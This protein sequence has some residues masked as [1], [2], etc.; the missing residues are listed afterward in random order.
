MYCN[1]CGMKLEEDALFCPNCGTK[2][3][4]MPQAGDEENRTVL[5]GEQ[6]EEPQETVV[7]EQP[8]ESQ[9]YVVEEQPA[10]P[11]GFV[12]EE[13]AV[14]PVQTEEPQGPV[15]EKVEAVETSPT[16]VVGTSEA[17]VVQAGY[18]EQKKFCPNCGAENGVNDLFC[19][20][21]GMFFG[22]AEKALQGNGQEKQKKNMAKIILPI[23]AAVAVII[24]CIVFVPRILGSLGSRG[25]QKDYLLYIKDNELNMA[26]G[27]KFEPLL[28]DDKCYEDKNDS[29]YSYNYYVAC[30]P[31][32]KYIYYPHNID[33]Y[34]GTY[35][36]YRKKL[37]D[38][39]AEEEKIDS[40][41][42]TYKLID[43]DR[44]AYVKDRD[45]MRLYIYSKGETS[46]VASDVTAW[47]IHVSDDGKNVMWRSNDGDGNLYVQD[48]A[49]KDDKVKLDSDVYLVYA[50]SSDLNL[51]VYEKDD[52]LYIL[53]D[54]EEKEKIASDVENVYVYGINNNL[55]IYYMKEGDEVE[56]T[57]YDL[58]D[59]DCRAADEN[60]VEPLIEDFTTYVDYYVALD[61]YEQ[62]LMRD[63]IRTW[64][65]DEE[66][67]EAVIEIY[68]YDPKKDENDKVMETMVIDGGNL[69][70][71]TALMYLWTV[72]F[73]D[74]EGP[75]MSKVIEENGYGWGSSLAV[76]RAGFEKALL[77]SQ[78]EYMKLQ[79][80]KDGEV[81]EV[82][83]IGIDRDDIFDVD[84]I[85][86]YSNEKTHTM[87]LV[88]EHYS[89]YGDSIWDVGTSSDSAYA[90]EEAAPDIESDWGSSEPESSSSQAY[91]NEEY[92]E[93]YSFDYNEPD[94]D[95][96]L[97]SDE[98]S[99]IEEICDE[100]IYYINE[101]DELY[102]NETK[103]DNDVA[104]Q[105]VR[106]EDGLV[107]YLTD[108]NK[109][110][111]EGTLKLYQDG[112]ASRIANDAAIGRYRLFDGDK[113][114]YMSDFNFNKYRGDLS[115]YDGKE[116]IKV[117]T[118]VQV[119]FICD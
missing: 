77:G 116:S 20:A 113:V 18:F 80:I 28:I 92:T 46:K 24:L 63:E 118:D 72:D 103:I 13:Q 25:N 94:A 71:D 53:K 70:T 87:Y 102:C 78:L 91:S 12:A 88:Y 75:K 114:V 47:D 101:D 108:I 109:D 95:T 52:N 33:S 85:S 99:S 19:Q 79:Y 58:I 83:D 97:V 76:I 15:I 62:K 3:S 22:D 27:S 57:L 84:D 32:N 61:E 36:L 117:D 89:G 43:N 1:N 64:A 90:I 66:M 112:K 82:S 9:G 106:C 11:Q 5:L 110:H 105:T 6:A 96:Q 69:G 73:E 31:D 98:V 81:F 68:H 17:A 65:Q 34:T 115:A 23:V 7:E 48:T 2:V 93:L 100:G 119:F 44:V 35:D 38:T 16:G 50:A 37:G 4:G 8:A 39:K 40:N 26:N 74:F 59:D 21:C 107:L 30:T 41:V 56:I 45:D 51:I 10:E 54:L 49:L 86:V 29:G 111:N 67:G 104:S 42:V 60:M 55:Q 14:E